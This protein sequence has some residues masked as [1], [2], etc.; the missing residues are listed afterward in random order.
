MVVLYGVVVLYGMVVVYG[1]LEVFIRLPKLG[2]ILLV[3]LPEPD[4]KLFI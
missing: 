3:R 2:I 1:K 4:S